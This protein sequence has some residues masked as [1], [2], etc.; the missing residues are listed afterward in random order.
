MGVPVRFYKLRADLRPDLDHLSKMICKGALVVVIHYFGY[1]TETGAIREIVHNAEGLLFEDCA[2]ALFAKALDADIA[3]WSLNKFLPVVDGAIL[4]SRKRGIN[5]AYQHAVPLPPRVM[6]A[7]HQYLELNARLAIC[8]DRAQVLDLENESR[9]AYEV[10]YQAISQDMAIHAQSHESTCIV[11]SIDLELLRK[12]RSHNALS[13]YKA[14]PECFVF[15]PKPPM[16]PFAYPIVVRPPHNTEDVFERLLNVGVLAPRLID[17]WDHI[18]KG[19]D[20]FLIEH[21]FMDQHLLLPV[22]DEVTYDD[23]KRVGACLQEVANA[24]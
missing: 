22:G 1:A 5:V 15:R 12:T 24:D 21:T 2:H 19:D 9:L 20:R 16:A 14:I 11:A 17:K 4:R 8:T 10:Y 18:P 6:G 13:Y 3:L 7:Y 23:I